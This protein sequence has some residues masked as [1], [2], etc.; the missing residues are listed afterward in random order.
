[1]LDQ[2]I[3]YRET[4]KKA[5][6]A[7]G[8]HK[9]QSGGS[10]QFGVV[11][12][13]FEP[14]N[15]NEKEFEFEEKIHGGSVPRNYF[16]AVEKGLIEH[17]QSGPLAGFPVIGVK[18]ILLD[19]AYHAV[20]SNE[21]SFKLAATLAFKNACIDAKPTLLEP[22]MKLDII[23]KDEYVGDVMGD[24]NKRRG[25]VLGMEP[26][27]G[28]KQKI[29]AEI[30]EAEIVSYTIDLMAMTQGTGSFQREFVRYEDVPESLQKGIIKH[31]E[32]KK[33]N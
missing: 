3:V 14:I 4:I 6:E 18:A 20:D 29:I 17:F 19:G 7:E 22:I 8:R 11:K 15:P 32:Q 5:T 28:G 21:L 24:A 33:N 9:K 10:G 26:M 12:M 2:E 16:P 1:M 31:F 13:L 30:P 27:Y 23:I 25:R